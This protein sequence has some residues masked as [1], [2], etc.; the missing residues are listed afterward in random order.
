MTALEYYNKHGYSN[1]TSKIHYEFGDHLFTL[2]LDEDGHNRWIFY[3]ND[4]ANQTILSKNRNF[5]KSESAIKYAE[6]EIKR[7]IKTL[8]KSKL[9]K[10]RPW[11]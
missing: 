7:Y 3:W 1:V 2:H 9:T 10:T 5:A 6:Q 4:N 11:E 8:T